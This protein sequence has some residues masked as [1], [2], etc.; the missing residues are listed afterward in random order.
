MKQF[1]KTMGCGLG[2]ILLSLMTV[3]EIWAVIK[4]LFIDLPTATGLVAVGKFLLAILWI[5]T[6]IVN[7]LLLGSG[8]IKCEEK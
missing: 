4:T 7:I 3:V 8:L 5:L 1:F 2:V 6:S